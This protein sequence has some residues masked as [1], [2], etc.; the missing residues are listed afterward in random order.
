MDEYFRESRLDGKM[1]NYFETVLI[2]NINQAAAYIENGVIPVDIVPFK[3]NN[4]KR[5]LGFYFYR[6]ETKEVFDKWCKY[7]L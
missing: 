4:G 3:D 5:T 7:E 6:K 2:K 1:Y